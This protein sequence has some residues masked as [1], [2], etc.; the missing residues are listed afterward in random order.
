MDPE[1]KIKA[2]IGDN[3]IETIEKIPNSNIDTAEHIDWQPDPVNF[4]KNPYADKYSKDFGPCTGWLITGLSRKGR[5]IS[6]LVHQ[7]NWD[8]SDQRKEEY[9]T[10]M[11]ASI[12]KFLRIARRGTLDSVQFAGLIS[13]FTGGVAEYTENV[14]ATSGILTK[15]LGF[16]PTVISGPVVE[17]ELTGVYATNVATNFDQD[18]VSKKWRPRLWITRFQPQQGLANQSFSPADVDNQMKRVKEEYKLQ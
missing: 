9:A 17:T 13:R 6:L 11:S 14:K 3:T 16:T 8:Y 15:E 18:P 12:R 7:Y 2:C 1:L 5:P 10:K 4:S